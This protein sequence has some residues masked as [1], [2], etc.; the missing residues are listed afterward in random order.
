M[1]KEVKRIYDSYLNT[2]T[3]SELQTIYEEFMDDI[4]ETEYLHKSLLG[5]TEQQEK[6]YTYLKEDTSIYSI[7]E[8]M[9]E[10]QMFNSTY[11]PL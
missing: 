10:Q 5:L 11:S 7:L 4:E 2:L 8:Q 9:A 6:D 1:R 3:I